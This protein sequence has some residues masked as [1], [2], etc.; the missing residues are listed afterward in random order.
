MNPQSKEPKQINQLFAHISDNGQM[1]EYRSQ[2]ELCPKRKGSSY[3]STFESK[4]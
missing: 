3:C 1:K 2:L 4:V